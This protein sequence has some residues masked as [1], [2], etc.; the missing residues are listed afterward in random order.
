[1]RM[2][3]LDKTGPEGV[4]PTGLGR[5][6]CKPTSLRP[7]GRG[8]GRGRGLGFCPYY[9]ATAPLSLADEEKILQKRLTE[10]QAAL[11]EERSA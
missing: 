2:P 6:G 11:K 7:Q 5:G 1:M 3:Q 4:G 9:E 10:V 8:A